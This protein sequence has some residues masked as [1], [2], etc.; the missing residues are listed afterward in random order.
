MARKQVMAVLNMEFN[1]GKAMEA[2]FFFF[3]RWDFDFQNG[4]VNEKERVVITSDDKLIMVYYFGFKPL[5]KVSI[6]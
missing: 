3:W 2:P 4:G 5:D 6:I 1:F